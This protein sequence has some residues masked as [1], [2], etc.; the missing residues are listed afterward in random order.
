VTVTGLTVPE[1]T[2]L[3]PPTPHVAVYPV[4][5]VPPSEDGGVKLMLALVSPGLA[6]SM[7]G[8]PGTVATGA[9]FGVAAAL[10]LSLPPP[11]PASRQA[12]NAMPDD[13]LWLR[14]GGSWW[15]VIGGVMTLLS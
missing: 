14:L 11:Q 2:R 3:V 9:G 10:L 1:P 8:A 15:D 6:V 5:A 12:S 13:N 4:M 7:V